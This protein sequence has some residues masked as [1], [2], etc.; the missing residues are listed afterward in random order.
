MNVLEEL[1]GEFERRSGLRNVRYEIIKRS[2]QDGLIIYV[3]YPTDRLYA[4]LDRVIEDLS[5][6][7]I[8][9]N[10]TLKAKAPENIVES[11]EGRYFIRLLSEIQNVNRFSFGADFMSRYT[12]SVSGA[13]SQIV[14]NANHIVY[15]R[16]GAGKSM[17]LLYAL[18]DRKAESRDSV[19]VDMQVYSKRSDVSVVADVL[20]SIL[21]QTSDI[22]KET[23]LHN[24]FISTLRDSQ[25]DE[26][27]IR[28]LLPSL[29]RLLG[30]FA[31]NGRDLF[32]FLDDFHVIDPDLQ[33]LMMDVVYAI[34]RGNQ[35]FIK[36]SAIETFTR[37]YNTKLQTGLEIGHDAQA[38]RLDYN[39]T[40]A[41]KASSHIEAILNGHANYAGIRSIRNLCTSKDV[42]P[43]LTWVAAGVPRDAISMFSQAM[44]KTSSQN[45]KKVS[46]SN[47]N[48][49]ASEMLTTKLK[50]LDQD[51]YGKK[52]SLSD[53]L[54]EIQEFCV[55]KNK[56]NAFLFEIEK[57][58]K[59]YKQIQ[60]LV[61]LRLLHVIS[62]GITV[63][64]AGR[65]YIG[66][67]LDYGFY[68]GIRAAQSVDLF[69][70]QS[71]RPTYKEVRAL[72]ILP[73]S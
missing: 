3:S 25:I 49:A 45:R 30:W 24:D 44:T 57:N 62:E 5:S 35:I 9:V 71:E 18:H 39:L 10:A 2:S 13:E 7:D 43:R 14:A 26:V 59:K 37:T 64:D 68:T 11:A 8:R 53:L 36:A 50:E 34:A 19:W 47:V 20:S 17:L 73:A 21:D 52:D 60:E 29:R 4:I 38:I 6:D 46:V 55:K 58:R 66:L 23:E 48:V 33:P 65:K 31:E 51:A 1:V 42:I 15:G 72:P 61:Q 28:S 56:K 27:K 41:D 63:G 16:R 54:E 67:I 32:V 70:K 12:R 22:I 69:N 40:V